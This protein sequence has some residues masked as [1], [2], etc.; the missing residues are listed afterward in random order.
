M[1]LCNLALEYDHGGQ[2]LQFSKKPDPYEDDNMDVFM[3][4]SVVEEH[5]DG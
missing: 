5:I 1:A 4:Y 3:I 2:Y